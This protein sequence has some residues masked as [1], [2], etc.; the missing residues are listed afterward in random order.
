[1]YL[2]LSALSLS[3]L[4]LLLS[5]NFLIVI[6]SLQNLPVTRVVEQLMELETT[7]VYSDDLYQ[8]SSNQLVVFFFFLTAGYRGLQIF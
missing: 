6:L 2:H 3:L 7:K 4:F 1:M 8:K 5:L